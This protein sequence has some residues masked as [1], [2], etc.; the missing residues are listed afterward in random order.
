MRKII[1][2]IVLVVLLA[3]PGSGIEKFP[4]TSSKIERVIVY[5]DRAMV[6]RVATLELREGTQEVVIENLPATLLEESIR[7][8][9]EKISDP[10]PAKVRIAGVEVKKVF[11]QRAEE[12]RM[13][14][15]ESEIRKL[16]DRDRAL[17]DKARVLN[18]KHK[19][20]ES[21]S[22]YSTEK[23]EKEMA[24]QKM[25]LQTWQN[26]LNFMTTSLTEVNESLQQIEIE[27]RELQ[28][29]L[30][31]L[32]K[33]MN[34][35]RQEK[36]LERRNVSVMLEVEKGGRWSL[37]V[38]YVV[39][40][41]GWRPI[42]D[43]RG[44]SLTRE[45]DIAYR[46]EVSQK[47]GED[48]ED[49]E[50]VLSTAKPVLGAKSPELL[51][52]YIRIVEP[53]LSL[54]EMDRLRTKAGM[55]AIAPQKEMVQFAAPE[56]T[57]TSQFFR[58]PKRE[59]IPGDGSFKKVSIALLTLKPVFKYITVPKVLPKAFL[60][61]N[62]INSTGYTFLAGEVNVFQDIDY[63]GK[64]Y[65]QQI[66]PGETF[67]VD[68]GVDERIKVERKLMEKK[69]EF[70][71]FAKERL[72]YSYKITVESFKDT[73]ET[74]TVVDQVPVSQDE[75]VS[76]K[77]KKSTFDQEPDEKGIIRWEFLLKPWE[78]KEIDLEFAIDYP[79]AMIIS[80]AE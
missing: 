55:P 64:S 35:I 61:A 15:L 33:E 48:W 41:A 45:I 69:K 36:P 11:L 47:T 9:E 43:I 23:I 26:A 12:S 77:I 73:A 22:R 4:A 7:A 3:N 13:K 46:A 30:E 42:Y 1:P 40:G 18:E 6:T 58:V 60:K 59:S 38:S 10:A 49:V 71:L 57:L 2:G 76:V 67:S 32:K 56:T 66:L 70:L 39:M 50:I 37:A 65:I 74:I 20:L 79:K 29:K 72:N 24:L 8:N 53:V 16:E 5:T 54:E 34:E 14:A 28:E 75:R 63:A 27:R 31:A 17:L 80:G 62:I 51:P 25:E 52:W 68:L 19:F 44:I 78:K 21:F